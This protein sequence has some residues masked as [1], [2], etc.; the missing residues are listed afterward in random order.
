MI[1]VPD[2]RKLIEEV[3]GEMGDKYAHL[4]AVTLVLRT[5][6]AESGY[7]NHLQ[8]GGGPGRGLWQ[9]ETNTAKDILL[10]YL[11]KSNK[12]DLRKTVEYLLGMP[13]QFD[14][15]GKRFGGVE[16]FNDSHLLDVHLRG[17]EVLGIILCRL[18]YWPVMHPLPHARYVDLQAQYW[19]K[20]YNSGGAGSIEHFLNR[21]KT[22]A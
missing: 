11:L 5:G 12:S 9:L 1:Y 2:M 18:K 10:R 15:D 8:I 22:V 17:N 3:L 13:S 14:K 19:L 4:D 7:F 16:A 6:A 21:A 20:W